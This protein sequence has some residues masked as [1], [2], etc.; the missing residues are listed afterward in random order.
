MGRTIGIALRNGE[1]SPVPDGF[2]FAEMGQRQR[3]CSRT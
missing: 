2:G 3:N 1:D